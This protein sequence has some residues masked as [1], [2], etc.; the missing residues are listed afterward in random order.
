M[1]RGCA[2]GD[3]AC[4]A[5]KQTHP[6][7]A[8]VPAAEAAVADAAVGV[9]G[10]AV[11]VP[12]DGV[13]WRTDGPQAC[14]PDPGVVV[15]GILEALEE[16]RQMADPAGEIACPANRLTARA[17]APVPATEVAAAVGA[18]DTAVVAVDGGEEWRTEGLQAYIPDSGVL[19]EG[20]QAQPAAPTPEL[21]SPDSSAVP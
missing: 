4:P 3:V 6:A 5:Y 11:A 7:T 9:A 20:T 19:Q 10:T 1:Q 15:A 17:T 14:N 16:G 2:A 18:V 12:I 21:G 13:Q 8:P